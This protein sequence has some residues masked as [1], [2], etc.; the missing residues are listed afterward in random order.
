[1]KER[2]RERETG[3]DDS[4]TTL[5][6]AVGLL[7]CR[8][9]FLPMEKGIFR[10]WNTDNT[11]VLSD[12]RSRIYHARDGKTHQIHQSNFIIC[13]KANI[14]CHRRR[15]SDVHGLDDKFQ[16]LVNPTKTH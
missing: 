2:Q 13:L 16:I 4:I 6:R 9:C 12:T 14:R 7:G 15:L 5:L 3:V 8:R 11:S 1:M 10:N